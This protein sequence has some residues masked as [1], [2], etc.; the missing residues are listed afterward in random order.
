MQE[1]ISQIYDAARMADSE[2]I[3]ARQKADEIIKNAKETAKQEKARII[4]DAE[5][6][7]E[8]RIKKANAE[9][10]K[11]IYDGK[12]KAED[13][14]NQL[15]SSADKNRDKAIKLVMENII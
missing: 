3:K 1:N 7:K 13:S 6:E 10:E 14:V 9:S 11:L 5:R 2:E 4:G 15:E 12:I 8:D